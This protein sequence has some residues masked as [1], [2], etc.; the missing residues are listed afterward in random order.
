M[1]NHLVSLEDIE[2]AGNAPP[3]PSIDYDLL[4]GAKRHY[5]QHDFVYVSNPPWIVNKQDA[6]LTAPDGTASFPIKEEGVLVAS[7]E[8]SFIHLIRKSSCEPGR[9]CCITP[10]FR[11]DHIDETHFRYFMKLELI[12]TETTTRTR[13]ME[14]LI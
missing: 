12:D 10:C 4:V 5:T 9:Y 6:E 1:T 8:Q 13:L 3:S 11:D 14:I 2:G 7:G